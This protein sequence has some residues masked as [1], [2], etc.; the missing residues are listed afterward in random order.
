LNKEKEFAKE[1]IDFIYDSP[2]A[3]HAVDSA[4]AILD[5]QGFIELKEED[6]WDLEK[7]GKYYVTKNDSAVTAFRERQARRTWL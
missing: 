7:G 2:T 1:L 4:K 3:F 5:K 6:R